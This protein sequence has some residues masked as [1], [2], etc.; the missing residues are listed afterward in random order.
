MSHRIISNKFRRRLI[1]LAISAAFTPTWALDLAESP[2]GT[3]EP[4]VR[5]NVIISIDDSGSMIWRLNSGSAGTKRTEPNVDGTWPTDTQRMSVLRYSLQSIF[6]PT[7]AKYDPNLIPD[8]KIRLAWQIMHNNGKSSSAGNVNSASMKTNS[9]RVLEGSHRTN[10]LDFLKKMSPSGGT[11][12]HDM[13]RNADEYMRLAPSANGPWSSNPGGSDGKSR[14]YLGCR[15]NYHIF[16][17]DGRWNGTRHTSSTTWWDNATN[18]TLDNGMRY[19]TAEAGT[20]LYRDTDNSH[21]LADWAFM[22]WARP[23]QSA[24][25]LAGCTPGPG[26]AFDIC[27]QPTADYNKA[28]T[29]ENFGTA[30]NP[31]IIERFWN[32]R[33]NPATWPHM[34]TYTIGFS[35]DAITWPGARDIIKP[36]ETLPFGYDGSFPDLV[37]GDKNWPE[38][39]SESR[40]SLDLWHAALNG[41]G[42]FYAVE[43]GQ[44]LEKAFR[45]IFQQIN[46]NTGGETTTSAISGTNTSRDNVGRYTSKYEPRDAWKGYVF[47]DILDRDGE[48]TPNPDWGVNAS[49]GVPINTADK[50]DARKSDHANRLVLSWKH[51]DV[52][53]NHGGDIDDILGQPISFTFSN[54]GATQK[55]WMRKNTASPV[56]TENTTQGTNRVNYIRGDTSKEGNTGTTLRQRLSIQG[57]IINSVTWYT[58]WPSASLPLKGYA[59]FA[60]AYNWRTPM[61]Y[62]GGNDGMLHGFSAV[63]GEEKIAYVPKGAIPKLRYLTAQDYDDKH[64][65]FVDGSPMTGD[66]DIAA[67][68]TNTDATDSHTPDW[69]TLLVGTM[70]LGGKGYFVLD[71]TNPGFSNKPARM[72]QA[73]SPVPSGHSDGANPNLVFNT[74]NASHLV[75]MDR[76]RST[77]AGSALVCGES[78][79][80]CLALQ[81]EERDI[82]HITAEP[83]HHSTDI[84]RSTQITRMNNNRWAVVMGNGYNSANQR[85]VLLVQYLDGDKELQL[86]PATT[87][88][89]GTGKANDNG[90]SAPRLVDLNGDDRTDIAYAGDNQGNLWKFDLTSFQ[91]S[92]WGVAFS[93]APLF[94]ATG[95]AAYGGSNRQLPQPITVAPTVRPNDRTACEADTDGSCKT[96]TSVTVGGMMV[97]F[98][99]GRNVARTDAES[100]QVQTLYSVLDNTRYR[101]KE[102]SNPK[103]LEVHDGTCPPSLTCDPNKLPDA[104]KALGAGVDA[105]K[106]LQQTT[107]TVAGD[108][109]VTLNNDPLSATSW[110]EGYNGWYLDLPSIGERLLKPLEFYDG[111]N[112]L[113]VYSQVPAKGSDID[114]NIETCEASSVD[115]ERQYRTFINI[116]DGATPSI[117]LMAVIDGT[118]DIMVRRQVR[119]GAHS[120]ISGK[121][122]HMHIDA[123][124]DVA[125][126]NDMP[127]PTS[128]PSWRQIQ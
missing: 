110:G 79:A 46:T 16:M 57:D 69:R 86:I 122:K 84:L 28:P 97:A 56:A 85:P 75:V 113:V 29:K 1:A 50:L 61:L 4:Y 13:L 89:P 121:D 93:G 98:G 24:S 112:I 7:H 20:K 106:L 45:D 126:L 66:V 11:P 12:S 103:R 105:A 109:M 48:P 127:A 78:D 71:V 3:V 125:N 117:Q 102:G 88:A 73:A 49:T 42:R 33:Y 123:N 80:E 83:V 119:K 63:N 34:V 124:H 90:L 31:A 70:G 15:R 51:E 116:M 53:A 72:G 39:N 95:P 99:T 128:R 55:I 32:P 25:N 58:G 100:N 94:S 92:N 91:P 52:L 38:M 8:G 68:P 120:M 111:S 10:F 81:S 60:K 27:I 114:P 62:V 17:T 14:E 41:R 76:T 6:D 35:N 23:L 21:T 18:L 67:K 36:T 22:S 74:G 96:G 26:G 101:Y 64:K 108:Q 9:M 59:A 44:D 2:P 40:R 82:G 77:E 5:P 54:L 43:E 30:E 104:P 118:T 19:R 87:D 115:E 37:R 47:S 107:D 65:F